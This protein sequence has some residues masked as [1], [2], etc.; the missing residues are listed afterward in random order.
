MEDKINSI[1]PLQDDHQIEYNTERDQLRMPE[2][3][4]HVQNLIKFAK[5]IEDKDKRQAFVE[6]VAEL[7][8]MLNPPTR[9]EED[10]LIKIWHHIFEIAD[11]DLDVMPPDGEIPTREMMHRKPDPLPYPHKDIRLRHYG[12]NVERLIQK[13]IEMEDE[14]KRREF[15]KV[16]AAY[17]KQAYRAWSREQFV[18]DDIIK[19]DLRALSGGLLTLDEDEAITNLVPTDQPQQPQSGQNGRHQKQQRK[20]QK[21]QGGNGGNRNQRRRRKKN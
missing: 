17:M 12:Y 8:F 15:V 20:R 13:A 14:E 7:M 9:N 16:I 5:T 18:N 21:K 1:H 19:S 11:F 6:K 10:H 2:Y 4:R 3:G